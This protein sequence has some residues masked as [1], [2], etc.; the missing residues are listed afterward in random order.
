M[1]DPRVR[2][3]ENALRDNASH[4][5]ESASVRW[6][7]EAP[8][9]GGATGASRGNRDNPRRVR[10]VEDSLLGRAQRSG[11]AMI[12]L[13]SLASLSSGTAIALRATRDPARAAVLETVAGSAL[14][15]GLSLIG[16]GLRMTV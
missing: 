1:E 5:A 11:V 15:L 7:P 8:E 9:Q 4:G 10:S 12:A 16:V 6:R 2:V 13:M 3:R 14:I